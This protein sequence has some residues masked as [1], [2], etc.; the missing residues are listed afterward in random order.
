MYYLTDLKMYSD[1]D[2]SSS[3]DDSAPPSSNISNWSDNMTPLDSE[4]SDY[5]TN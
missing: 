5:Y 4:D 1:S 2:S 3:N